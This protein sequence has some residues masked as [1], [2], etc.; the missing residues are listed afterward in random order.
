MFCFSNNLISYMNLYIRIL[1]LLEQ[2]DINGDSE[3]LE[4]L[5]LKN[6]SLNKYLTFYYSLERQKQIYTLEIEIKAPEE[7]FDVTS[8][9]IDLSSI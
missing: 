1:A 2:D 5:T 7:G 9:E 4:S 3:R 8:L 6:S